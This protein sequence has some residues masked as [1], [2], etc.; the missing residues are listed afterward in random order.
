FCASARGEP[1][2]VELPNNRD[3]PM[4]IV[5]AICGKGITDLTLCKPKTSQGKDVF[6]SKRK[7]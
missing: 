7:R 5:G 4:T 3:I 2:K 6:N 1:A